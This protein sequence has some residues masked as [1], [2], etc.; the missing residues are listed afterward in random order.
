MKVVVLTF[1]SLCNWRL[2]FS[3]AEPH[4]EKKKSTQR[5]QVQLSLCRL[6]NQRN[7]RVGLTLDVVVYC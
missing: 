2:L 5:K 6:E 3:P 1:K 7:G 4:W